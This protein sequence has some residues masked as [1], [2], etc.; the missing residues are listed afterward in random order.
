M[1]PIA[2]WNP[3]RMLWESQDLDLFSGHLVPFSETFPTSGMTRSGLLWPLPQSAHRTAANACSSSQLLPTPVTQP[4]TGNGH[5][6][7]LGK[8]VQMLPTPRATDDTKRGPNQ[9]G[10]AGDLMLPSAV[11]DLLPSPRAKQ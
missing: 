9:R 8:E 7:N 10:S 11:M 4:Q 2:R 3:N 6:R 5:A 1:E